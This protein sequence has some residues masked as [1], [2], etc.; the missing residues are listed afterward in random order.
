MFQRQF[1]SCNMSVFVKKFCRGRKFLSPH[2]SFAKNI[3]VTQSVA[4]NSAGLNLCVMKQG[5]SELIFQCRI[6]CTALANCPRCNIEM[7]QYPLRVHLL[8]YCPC[9]TLPMRTHERS[10]SPLHVPTPFS[11]C[12]SADLKRDMGQLP[13]NPKWHK[14]P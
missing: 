2:N 10:L 14:F 12:V 9:N 3:L 13:C 5:Q 7:S 1:P 8:A 4:W 6:A 11:H